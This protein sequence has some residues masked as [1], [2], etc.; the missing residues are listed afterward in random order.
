M[1]AKKPK[2]RLRVTVDFDRHPELYDRLEAEEKN[3]RGSKSDIVRR[4]L[5]EHF[6]R[7]QKPIALEAVAKRGRSDEEVP[8]GNPYGLSSD[9]DDVTEL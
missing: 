3:Y 7:E 6:E 5:H 4:A 1:G 9:D 2:K 8:K